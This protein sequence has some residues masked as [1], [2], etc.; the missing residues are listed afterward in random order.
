MIQ[1]SIKLWAIKLFN[2]KNEN[3]F[4]A[5]YKLMLIISERSGCNPWLGADGH[6][7]LHTVR[8]QWQAVQWGE[9]IRQVPCLRVPQ[10]LPSHEEEL[11]PSGWRFASKQQHGRGELARFGQW[12]KSLPLHKLRWL[13]PCRKVILFVILYKK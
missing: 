11:V 3:I 10:Q 5:T 9:D 13:Q 7:Q 8:V 1:F 4:M 12:R 2:F 6:R